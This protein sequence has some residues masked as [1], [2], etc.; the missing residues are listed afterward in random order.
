MTHV[1]T[2]LV[3]GGGIAGPV[4]AAALRKVGVEAT[5]FERADETTDNVGGIIGLAPNGM[6][7]LASVGLDEAV[8]KVCRPVPSMVLLSGTGKRLAEFGSAQAGPVLHAVWRKD[9][10]LALAGEAKARGVRVEFGKRLVGVD[11]SADS[12]TARFADGTSATADILIGADG[13]RSTV[14]SLIDP[15]APG[16][17]YTGLLS[18]G[19]RPTKPLRVPS[20][21]GSLHMVYGKKAIF[22]YLADDDETGWFVNMPSKRAM[23]IAQARAVGAAEWQRRLAELFTEDRSPAVEIISASDPDELV[24]VGGVDDLPH[25][26]TWHRGRM[27]LIGDSA[28]ATSP[29]SGQGGSMAIESGVQVARCL[30]DLPSVPE[31]FAAY[32]RLRRPRVERVIAEGRKVDQSKSPGPVGRALRDLLLPTM[33]KLIAKPERRAWQFDHRIDFAAAVSPAELG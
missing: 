11:E 23:T 25:V 8:H 22:C 7:A 17:R 13:I 20:T 1:R 9:L 27:I 26:P 33:M 19:G 21:H 10:F 31:A 12:V 14:R 4:A 24:I 15:S 16:P 32:E 30:R 29:S 28:H 18:F 5:V 3:I 2:A 6:N